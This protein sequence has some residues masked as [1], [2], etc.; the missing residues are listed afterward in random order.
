MADTTPTTMKTVTNKD[1]AETMDTTTIT[2]VGREQQQVAG[3]EMIY[4]M[5][6]ETHAHTLSKRSPISHTNAHYRRFYSRNF[7]PNQ[8]IILVPKERRIERS[9]DTGGD[10]RN[11]PD[12]GRV[13][14]KY[15]G[16]GGNNNDDDR[17]RRRHHDGTRDNR[18][19]RDDRRPE[20][21]RFYRDK[22]RGNFDNDPPDRSRYRRDRSGSGYYSD[23]GYDDF[24]S[25]SSKHHEQPRFRDDNSRR[26]SF[27][28]GDRH[29]RRSEDYTTDEDDVDR[30]GKKG[31]ESKFRKQPI[32]WPPC[33]QKKE[34]AFAF[35]ARSA[36]FYE[37]LSDFFYDPKSK[38]YYGNKKCAYYRYDKTKDPPF[39]E[40]QK[41]TSDQVEEQKQ[42]QEGDN[43]V[44]IIEPEKFATAG[45][46]PAVAALSS[47]PKIAIKFKTKKVKSSVPA[48]AEQQQPAVIGSTVS[49]AKQQQIANIGK[50]NE[51][52]A[53]LKKDSSSE[54]PS[55][56]DG[57]RKG[58]APPPTLPHPPKVRTT[59]KGE[60]ICMIC[61]RKFPNLAK[62]R[63]HEKSSELHKKNLLKLQETKAKNDAKRSQS[64]GT[65][66][67]GT[68]RKL[69]DAENSEPS[70]TAANA[71]PPSVYTDRAEKRRQLH[72]VDVGAPVHHHG[73]HV[74][75]QGFVVEANNPTNETTMASVPTGSNPLDET[76]VGRQL[77]QKMG[78][79]GEHPSDGDS[80]SKNSKPKTASDHLRKEWDRIEAMAQKS[81]SRY[82]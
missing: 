53:E 59:A 25:D 10:R 62:L 28:R 20:T 17:F 78:Y 33:F 5:A 64:P 68:K 12:D 3:A 69:V 7:F 30:H 48:A 41:L 23:D 1:T 2:V 79:T 27:D 35:D 44:G 55:P 61:K 56:E 39:V 26:R 46:D 4:S 6:A 67:A 58:E 14:Q 65:T 19:C 37:P 47:K 18:Y 21:E 29:R 31:S 54:Q 22:D 38:L 71:P 16:G 82:R 75:Q 13:A 70:T 8:K 50:W 9:T 49:K 77:L 11:D 81:V 57:Q 63:L 72:G 15:H 45:K 74:L 43:N 32:E 73:L 34:S 40:V 80:D 66:D 60:P 52:Q 36:M 51:K 76:N 24:R 42:K